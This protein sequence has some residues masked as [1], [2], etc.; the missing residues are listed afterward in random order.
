M[1]YNANAPYL[2]ETHLKISKVIDGDSIKVVSQFSKTE[3]EIR[4]YGLDCPETQKSRKLKEDEMKTHVAGEFL[5]KLGRI[6]TEFVLQ[7]APPGTS[8]TLI[9]EQINPV[10][11]YGRQ[12][13]Y[14]ILPNGDCLNELL[15]REGYAKPMN[16]YSCG[17]L[18][19]FQQLNFSA[20]QSG[21]GL[22]AY[23]GNF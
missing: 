7:Y 10:D 2:T 8:V 4:L 15:L 21:K 3:K 9:T 14:V 12:L 11:Y 5:L 22:Y 6:A 18:P 1:Q 19:T 20:K 16:E 23:I 17:M 13:A